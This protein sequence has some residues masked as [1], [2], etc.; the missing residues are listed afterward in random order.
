MN[1]VLQFSIVIWNHWS[2]KKKEPKN[3][4]FFQVCNC[5][6]LKCTL[7]SKMYKAIITEVRD[8]IFFHI[9]RS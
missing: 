3:A 1:I 5:Y 6:G 8:P 9:I 7:Q 2:K 4:R